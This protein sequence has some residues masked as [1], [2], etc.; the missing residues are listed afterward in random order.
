MEKK[1]RV[2]GDDLPEAAADPRGRP[3]NYCSKA[4][5]RAAEFEIRR[6]ERQIGELEASIVAVRISEYPVMG[7][8]VPRVEAEILRQRDR[9]LKLLGD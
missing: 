6:V 7:I 5:R 9:L 1:C 2:C 3:R 4:C 8:S